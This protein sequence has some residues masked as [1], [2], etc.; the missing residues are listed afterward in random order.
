M[1][2][3][4]EKGFYQIE[5]PPAFEGF[6]RETE[7]SSM[8]SIEEIRNNLQTEFPALN[9][10]HSRNEYAEVPEELEKARSWEVTLE[11]GTIVHI[12]DL[13]PPIVHVDCKSDGS[14]PTV[15]KNAEQTDVSVV[16]LMSTYKERLDR[17]P[18]ESSERG[19]WAGERGESIFVP[20]DPEIQEIMEQFES[21]GIQYKN[22]I[23]D[24]SSFSECTVEIKNM[25]AD[26]EGP[27][28]NFDQCDH[29][30][31]KQWNLESHAG[32]TD[33]SAAQVRAWRKGNGYSWHERN[34]M[35]TCDLIPTKVNDYFGHLGG[36]G[37]CL[38]RDIA[39]EFGGEFDE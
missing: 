36:V 9:A 4:F 23:P 26:R 28:K 2:G 35:K 10:E 5:N 38:R 27:G 20:N 34:D 12:P 8:P 25:S 7:R 17:T 3:N 11:D 39:N 31:T 15:Q 14:A 24:F 16:E 18:R 33:W 13:S 19:Q 32:K 30:C 29:A 22:G 37:E 6:S 1:T 21:E